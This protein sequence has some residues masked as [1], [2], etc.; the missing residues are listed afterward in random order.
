IGTTK[1]IFLL[2][3][4]NPSTASTDQ[5]KVNSVESDCWWTGCQKNDWAVVGCGQYNM[6]EKTNRNCQDGKEYNCCPKSSNSNM[7]STTSTTSTTT[8]PPPPPPTVDCWWT[9]CQKNSWASV[10]CAQYNRTEK[11]KRECDDG[12]EYYCCVGSPDTPSKPES[13]ECWWSTCQLKNETTRGCPVGF[14]FL[15]SEPCEDGDLF[16]CCE[17]PDRKLPPEVE[18]LT[19]GSYENFVQYL[20]L[21]ARNFTLAPSN[22]QCTQLDPGKEVIIS[23]GENDGIRMC[24]LCPSFPMV[25]LTDIFLDRIPSNTTSNV[26]FQDCFASCEANAR[27]LAFSYDKESVTCYMFNSTVGLFT[28]DPGWKTVLMT[29][30]SGVIEN[31][32]YSRHTSISGTFDKIV[33]KTQ[34]FRDCLTLCSKEDS[35]KHVSFNVDT[36]QCKMYSNVSSIDY[37]DLNYG[38]LTAFDLND[39][40]ASNPDNSWRFT[41]D[42]N[43]LDLLANSKTTVENSCTKMKNL[44]HSAYF[45]K[46]CYTSGALGCDSATGC[47]TCYYPENSGQLF[48]NNLIA[49]PD[50]IMTKSFDLA[51]EVSTLR[52]VSCL[53]NPNCFGV[54]VNGDVAYSEEIVPE[55]LSKAYQTRYM[56]RYPKESKGLHPF[57]MRNDF[58]AD[59]DFVSSGSI[60]EVYNEM[61]KDKLEDCLAEIS[62][63][64]KITKVS[65]SLSSKKCKVG[66]NQVTLINSPNQGLITMIKHPEISSS[67][68]YY[69]AIY[70]VTLDTS[71]AK[72]NMK[73]C[74]NCEETC[75]NYC[76]NDAK[77]WC[78]YYSVSYAS[79]SGQC[80]F[81]E[82][83][84]SLMVKASDTTITYKRTSTLEFNLES[85]NRLPLFQPDDFYGCFLGTGDPATGSSSSKTTGVALRSRRG[86]FDKIGNFF[87][88][89]GQGIVDTVKKTVNTVVDTAK[90]VVQSVGK[91]IKG[92]LKGAKDAFMK[93]PV[94]NDVKNVV[95]LGG[96]VIKGDWNKV[97]E[98]GA[99][100]LQSS[101][102]DLI[103]TVIPGGKILGKGLSAA[104]KALGNTGKIAKND[105]KKSI[106]KSDTKDKKLKDKDNNNNN[107]N[108]NDKNRDKDQRGSQCPRRDNRTNRK[109]RATNGRKRPGN[110]CDDE[111][112]GKREGCARPN[113]NNIIDTT[114][115][116][117]NNRKATAKCNFECEP[118]YDENDPSVTCTRTGKT[119]VWNPAPKCTLKTCKAGK[120]V[121]IV[122][123]TPKSRLSI[124]GTSKNVVAYCVLFDSSR[125]LPIWSVTFQQSS[126]LKKFQNREHSWKKYPCTALATK[127]ADDGD[128]S[129]TNWQKGHLTPANVALWSP[130][131]A[132]STNL[133][134]NEAPADR[135]TNVGSWRDLEAHV[136]C[137][138][139]RKR[140]LVATGVCD[141]SIG[142]SK[143][144]GGVD[145]PSC[146]WKLLCYEDES[147]NTVVVGFKSDNS[148]ISTGDAGKKDRETRRKQIFTP[149][150]QAEI[151][152]L[153]SG[154]NPWISTAT[155]L[156]KG[157]EAEAAA[158]ATN[159]TPV[160]PLRCAAANNLV[161]DEKDAWAAA[162]AR[163][164]YDIVRGK[165]PKKPKG[166]TKKKRQADRGLGRGCIDDND[167]K[168]ALSLVGLAAGLA[169]LGGA[170]GSDS[171]IGGVEDNGDG[172]VQVNVQS[173]G[174]RIIGYYTSWGK[175]PITGRML[176]KLTHVIYAFLE[177]SADGTI[178]IGSPDRKNSANIAE[179]TEKARKR[180]E[181]LMSLRS[182]YPHVKIM[183]AVG[184][185]ENSQ[186]FSAIASSPSMRQTFMSSVIKM[187]ETWEFDGVDIDWEYPVTGGANEG[188]P[189]DKE[190]YVTLMKEMRGL[191]DSL[192]SE[193]GRKDK[194]LLSFA[195]AAGQWTLDPGFDLPGLLKYADFANIMTYDY[196]GA[197]ASKWG[198]Y[199]GP[200][201]PLFFG[202]P[203][204]FSGKTNTAW[205]VK[206]YTCKSK[207]PHKLNM[208]VPFYGRYWKNVGDP[209]DG[210]DGMW[211]TATAVNGKFEGDFVPWD[212]IGSDY[213]SNP[214]FTVTF[215]E[216][217]KTPYAWSPSTKTFLGFENEQSLGEKVKY[218]V[219][220]NVGGLMVWAVDLDDDELTLLDIVSK[221]PLCS[222]TDPNDNKHVCSPIDE[223]RWWTPEDGSDKEGLCG[224]SAPLYKG[225]YPVC[226]PDD[227]GYSCCG[228]FGYCG[229]GPDFCDCPSCKDFGKNPKIILEGAIKPSVPVQW[230]ILSDP[231]GKR[232]RC[233][234]KI[235]KL[236]GQY[237]ICNPD[238]DNNHCCSNGGYC[239]ATPEHCT[240]S[241]CVDFRKNPNYKWG[242]KKWWTLE[243]GENLGGACGPKAP[244][245][246][247]I[248]EAEC[249][250]DSPTHY[251]C[252][253]Q[254]W[255]GAGKDFCDCNG[256]KNFKNKS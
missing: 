138:A 46:E 171:P 209:V 115:S 110:D 169:T 114:T 228:K 37:I 94:V 11:N 200:P 197:W 118:G 62:K 3:P 22:L 126:D 16:Q 201:A 154:K 250:P 147:D 214:S 14:D 193:K 196:F 224:K 212:K 32:Y 233:G 153:Y 249:D 170:N 149:L 72:F 56:L 168:S 172:S 137:F 240:C 237:P 102:L 234:R 90:G 64:D 50:S 254:G 222:N 220:K 152:K 42:E 163:I 19:G 123:E 73:D 182:M 105:V 132:Q 135:T 242:P 246:D 134:L 107:N 129:G 103:T 71:K 27:C 158:G 66:S 45:S 97:K 189:S 218:A 69:S 77:S 61:T 139:G 215:H 245:V 96:A 208:G 211:R 120:E 157:R 100:L 186:Y 7:E 164:D 65:Y 142:K 175:K 40:S 12:K 125:K 83:D 247:G 38:W 89:V 253:S 151:G 238:D 194:Y 191:L 29:Q 74:R 21:K 28:S 87:K 202:M 26:D 78:G 141:A 199:T 160:N 15:S 195:G 31:W 34:G 156:F 44:T 82:D 35:C 68:A 133:Y 161:D 121:L 176:Q 119:L 248:Y 117:C 53:S 43:N 190:N 183:F 51:N 230:Y 226:D 79:N 235:E 236:N 99:D 162:F 55:T 206:Y 85:L 1:L 136:R 30:P 187:I 227:P 80:W 231:D 81:Y 130:R 101:T 174:K 54:G 86:I 198:A 41:R 203:P 88:K 184:G 219:D 52:M 140:I 4:S 20:L 84:D 92:D 223:K 5:S 113:V 24:D 243:D 165:G 57:L 95:E 10:G 252:S 8:T 225:Y 98:K 204:R 144:L 179:E 58:L 47:R 116:E 217:S 207:L 39:I 128:Y 255:C 185:W 25:Y 76:K 60:T 63:N 122:L 232:G 6:T 239:G 91:V 148:Q 59:Y 36:T 17:N 18:P 23:V 112:D 67:L 256:C 75:A 33:E 70:G 93:I 131:A 244:K 192:Q 167:F 49:C 108:N 210:K 178:N 221:A 9:G 143:S 173:C 229:T 150:S 106:G 13:R 177:T 241:G 205:T 111:D 188:V 48:D 2:I 181:H 216:K 159:W 213:L 145:V 251:C 155:E 127:Q 104:G 166:K 146:F 180:L 109:R 124:G